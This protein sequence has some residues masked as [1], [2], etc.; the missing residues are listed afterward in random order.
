MMMK[1]IRLTGSGSRISEG[2]RRRRGNR[3]CASRT[4]EP[5]AQRRSD[6]VPL[7]LW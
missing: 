3:D 4:C 5:G 6:L 7:L 1:E 2:P